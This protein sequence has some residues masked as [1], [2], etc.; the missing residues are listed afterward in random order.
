MNSLFLQGRKQR[1]N[2]HLIVNSKSNAA[3]QE[4]LA[5]YGLNSFTVHIF[6]LVD[7]GPKLDFKRWEEDPIWFPCLLFQLLKVGKLA[8]ERRTELY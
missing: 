4:A 8:R 6:K 1:L 5:T 2:H 7:L 3:L